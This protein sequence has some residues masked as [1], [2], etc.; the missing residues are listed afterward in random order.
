MLLLVELLLLPKKPKPVRLTPSSSHIAM[1]P[2]FVDQQLR[3]VNGKTRLSVGPRTYLVLLSDTFPFFERPEMKNTFFGNLV[4]FVFRSITSDS[5][6][7]R[8]C[9]RSLPW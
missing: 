1:L 6:V 2:D 8:N 3:A 7:L 5:L 9:C 4:K